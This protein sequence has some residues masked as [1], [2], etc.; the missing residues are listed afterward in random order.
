MDAIKSTENN[1]TEVQT[2]LD[3]YLDLIEHSKNLIRYYLSEDVVLD[4]FGHTVKGQKN[5]A[6][7]MKD[8]VNPVKHIFKE[9]RAIDSIG[10][11]DT[12]VV[13]TSRPARRILRSS[14]LSP[15]RP[16]LLNTPKKQPQASTSA[17]RQI[18]KPN[19][20]HSESP[21]APLKNLSESPRKRQKLT[22]THFDT[23]DIDILESENCIADQMVKYLTAEGNVEFHRP[24]LKKLQ[25]ETKWRRPSKLHIAYNGGKDVKDTSFYLIIYEGN[26]KCR[27][28]L[29]SAFEAEE[30]ED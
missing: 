5:V 29:I 10:F 23:S 26:V 18:G 1:A 19:F 2:V 15:P 9:A 20:D 7:F 14:L 3:F 4:W 8:K 22:P 21:P 16:T 11:R 25:R 6:A 13:K 24:S 28:N 12:H 17:R 27:K 30:A